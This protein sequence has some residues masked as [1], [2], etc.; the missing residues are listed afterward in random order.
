M[1]Y[2]VD[3]FSKQNDTPSGQWVRRLIMAI[4][5]FLCFAFL[6]HFLWPEGRRF[7]QI[8]LIPGDPEQTLQAVQVFSEEIDCGFSFLDALKN[9]CA[10]VVQHGNRG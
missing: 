7:L 5:F 3:Y 6:V 10:A 9:L 2:R 1:A 8:M 4:S